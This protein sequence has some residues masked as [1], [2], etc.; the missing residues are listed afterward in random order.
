M[1]RPGYSRLITFRRVDATPAPGNHDSRATKCRPG[2]PR[3]H[4]ESQ[5]EMRTERIWES[6][7]WPPRVGSRKRCR[8]NALAGNVLC[9][10]SDPRSHIPSKSPMYRK[11][12]C[13]LPRLYI[14]ARDSPAQG[15][16]AKWVQGFSICGAM[17]LLSYWHKPGTTAYFSSNWVHRFSFF[18]MLNPHVCAYKPG[19]TTCLSLNSQDWPKLAENEH[20]SLKILELT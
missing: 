8:A 11:I 12:R 17:N 10:S 15:Y 7:I 4:G 13:S 6:W 18:G 14:E 19:M 16:S 3:T 20:N 2:N 5:N 9:Q 1:N